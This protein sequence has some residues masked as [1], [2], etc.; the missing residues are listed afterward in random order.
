MA[1]GFPTLS[2]A[3]KDYLAEEKCGNTFSNSFCSAKY[4][5]TCRPRSK[6]LFF[7]T[8]LLQKHIQE[9]IWISKNQ[10]GSIQLILICMSQGTPRSKTVH[11]KWSS[12]VI[13]IQTSTMLSCSGPIPAQKSRGNS[14]L[15]V[16]FSHTLPKMDFRY[17]HRFS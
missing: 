9:T 5:S 11:F 3:L 8:L 13:I 12:T 2:Q 1:T 10:H 6:K 16:I 14:V 4:R 7:D 15:G 17:F